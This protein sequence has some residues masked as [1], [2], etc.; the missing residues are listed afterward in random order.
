MLKD[1]RL[2]SH[3]LGA[4]KIDELPQTLGE[5]SEEQEEQVSKNAGMIVPVSTDAEASQI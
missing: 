5:Q 4:T 3:Y 1:F 2:F